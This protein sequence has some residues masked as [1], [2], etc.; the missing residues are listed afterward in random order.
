MIKVFPEFNP[1]KLDRS[2][3]TQF[4]FKDSKGN[5]QVL[6]PAESIEAVG[7]DSQKF[8]GD[9]YAVAVEITRHLDDKTIKVSAG[10]K[11]ILA[12]TLKR[13]PAGAEDPG[14]PE[15]KASKKEIK[16]ALAA[17]DEKYTAA[18]AEGIGKAVDAAN[19]KHQKA[20]DEAATQAQAEK[21][22]A[23]A[24]ADKAHE[25]EMAK[26]QTAHEKTLSKASK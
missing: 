5:R 3:T 26:Q 18:M 11:A 21:E 10:D 14:E 12:A 23:L 22:Q 24:E 2:L 7:R 4:I 6:S 19:A 20:V 13:G 16:E 17:A 15:K 8:D 1:K 25:E 9:D